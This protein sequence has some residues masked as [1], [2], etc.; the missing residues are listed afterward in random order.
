MENKEIKRTLLTPAA[1]L[2]VRESKG[3]GEGESRV[4]TGYAILFNS[5]SEPLWSEDYE[6]AREIISPSAI[7]QE[8]LDAADIKFT[9]FHD[10][11]II[12]ARSNKGEGSLKYSIDDKGVSFEFTA[13]NTVYGDYALDAVKRGDIS[14]CSFAFSTKYWTKEYVTRSEKMVGNRKLITFTVNQVTGIYDMA[15]AVDPAYSGTTVE[16][17][18]LT[19]AL[20]AG[21]NSAEDVAKREK[22]LKQVA[23]M[24]AAQKML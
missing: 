13:P 12:L 3:E 22:R 18:E 9:M 2:R 1:D 21:G 14:G 10:R 4:I 6:E 11:Q 15:L 19:T 8:L 7:T 20:R 23:E 5:P 24:R 16:A 17:R